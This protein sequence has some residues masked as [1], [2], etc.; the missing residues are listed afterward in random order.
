[1]ITRRAGGRGALVLQW[2]LGL[3]AV[4][5]VVSSVSGDAVLAALRTVDPLLYAVFCVGVALLNLLLDSLSAVPTHRH[6]APD[7]KR[8]EYLVVRGAAH[9][10]GAIHVHLGQAQV[11]W[12]LV[13]VC[14]AGVTDVVATTLVCYG[15]TLGAL[16]GLGIV[17]VALLD[18]PGWLTAGVIGCL[19]AASLYGV[20]LLRPP[21][22]L[23]RLR[24][25]AKLQQIGVT[26]QVALMLLRLPMMA[27]AIAELWIAYAF[28]GLEFSFAETMAVMPVL[29]LVSAVPLV[30][31][32][33][34]ARDLTAFALLGT[35]VNAQQLG[36]LVSAGIA[37]AA[38][39]A[40]AQVVVGLAFMPALSR[41]RARRMGEASAASS[42]DGVDP[43]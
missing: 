21:A 42:G 8:S 20:V 43:R 18:A 26:T 37:L 19:V 34:G 1:M 35:A 38:G 7:L 22:V 36:S 17:P 13:R 9:L 6:A 31:H 14:G 11:G 29:A 3:S 5:W 39:S 25:F 32:G 28:F 30:P 24:V 41:L 15:T 16:V 33:I 27:L 40:L 23:S 2:V 12:L 4:A 10:G